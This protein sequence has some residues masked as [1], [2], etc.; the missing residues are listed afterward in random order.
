MIEEYARATVCADA[1]LGEYSSFDRYM[2]ILA[3]VLAT[4]AISWLGLTG[5]SCDIS[6]LILPH[7]REVINA[8]R[9]I[10]EVGCGIILLLTIFRLVIEFRSRKAQKVKNAHLRNITKISLGLLILLCAGVY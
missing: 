1:T 8:T 10:T 7:T 9:V 4:D 2:R 6:Y 3:V 5:T